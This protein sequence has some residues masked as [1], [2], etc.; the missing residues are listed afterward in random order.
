MNYKVL[1]PTIGAGAAYFAALDA[2]LGMGAVELL[3]ELCFS[4]AS[5]EPVTTSLPMKHGAHALSYLAVGSAFASVAFFAASRE[6]G[7]HE[8]DTKQ[9]FHDVDL[10]L[11]AALSM[12]ANASE[13]HGPQD[14]CDAYH[15][16]Y[17]HRPDMKVAS[18]SYDL[19][20][21]ET[22]EE[23]LHI[24]TDVSDPMDR[25]RIVTA[26][27]DFSRL[28]CDSD[29]VFEVIDAIADAMD[30]D[31]AEIA[32]AQA[33]FGTIAG[34]SHF[35]DRLRQLRMRFAGFSIADAARRY[36]LKID[37]DDIIF[38]I[39]PRDWVAPLNDDNLAQFYY[40]HKPAGSPATFKYPGVDPTGPL[41]DSTMAKCQSWE[42][43]AGT[44]LPVSFLEFSSIDRLL[45]LSIVK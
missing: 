41:P 42:P 9:A 24:F 11:M 40:V 36:Q 44:C 43:S 39:K 8:N 1:I 22:I 28:D 23:D 45:W 6:G 17:G 10:K 21:L 37:E 30:M 4:E 27:M 35:G 18:A 25:A 32:K 15:R 14:I 33:T 5:E 12:V 20:P 13:N 19:F 38:V 26:A 31:V 16:A 7:A 2:H 3:V 29:D 34:N